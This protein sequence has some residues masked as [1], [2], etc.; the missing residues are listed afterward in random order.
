MPASAAASAAARA[1]G[2]P[3]VVELANRGVSRRPQLA[4][5]G[6]VRTAY[7]LGRL[8]LGLGEHLLPP[9]PEVPARGSAAERPLERVAVRADEARQGEASATTR[10]QTLS[11][12]GITFR[13]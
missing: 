3:E 6:R 4:I 2:E 10:E 12:S 9:G 7:E 8:P 1:S 13:S 5:D 11:T